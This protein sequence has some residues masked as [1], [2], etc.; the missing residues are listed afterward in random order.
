MR[1]IDFDAGVVSKRE[2]IEVS[3]RVGIVASGAP[4]IKLPRN[5]LGDPVGIR[6]ITLFRA[7]S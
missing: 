3:E 6:G 2:N 7:T 1:N 4:I 5:N